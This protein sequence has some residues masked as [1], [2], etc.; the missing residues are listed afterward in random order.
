MKRHEAVLR[1]RVIARLSEAISGATCIRAYGL[2]EWFGRNV[3]E[4][5]DDMDS[6]YFLTMA[7]QRWLSVRL[8]AVGTALVF[9]TG[10]LIVA[11]RLS[12]VPGIA[13]LVIAYVFMIVQTLQFTIRQFA[14]VENKMNATE[15]LHY[16]ATQ[17]EQETPQ[18]FSNN[19]IE[20]DWPREGRITFSNVQMRYRSELPLVFMG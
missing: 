13:G 3:C 7:N 11:S 14:E 1:S 4:A 19:R 20:P 10:I 17:L 5:I 6:A 12:V 18:L 9:V 8:N 15:R 2:Q 16:Y